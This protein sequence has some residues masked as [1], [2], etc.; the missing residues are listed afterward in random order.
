MCSCLE[1]AANQIQKRVGGLCTERCCMSPK[2]SLISGQEKTQC[3]SDGPWHGDGWPL[4]SIILLKV[5]SKQQRGHCLI[6]HIDSILGTGRCKFHLLG[7]L[8]LLTTQR[9]LSEGKGLLLEPS[10]DDE[11]YQSL[12]FKKRLIMIKNIYKP[13]CLPRTQQTGNL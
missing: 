9:Q 1:R 2:V 3:W 10:L 4:P 5:I 8:Q 12:I 11:P 6:G 13:A 7:L